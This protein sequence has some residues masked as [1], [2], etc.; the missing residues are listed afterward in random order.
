MLLGGYLYAHALGSVKSS[1]VQTWIHLGLLG[2]SLLFLP[3]AP[4]AEIWEDAVFGRPSGRIL[5]LLA[6]RWR[7]YFLL[8]STAPLVQRWFTVSSDGRASLAPLRPLQSG[9]VFSPC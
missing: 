5:L 2:A 9:I 4:S 3:I 8:S 1:R 6:S 7:P